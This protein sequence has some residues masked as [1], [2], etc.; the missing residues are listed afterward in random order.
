MVKKHMPKLPQ[1]SDPNLHA[2]VAPEGYAL[3]GVSTLRRKVK[4][5]W[6]EDQ[7]WVK[8][9]D[10]PDPRLLAKLCKEAV[11]A[12]PPKRAK[13][14]RA[15]HK[16]SEQAV[17]I[18][19]GD[20]HFGM[21]AWAKEAGDDWDLDI[22]T[23]VHTAAIEEALSLVPPSELCVI[24][25]LGDGVHADGTSGAT[26]AG[27]RVDTD[28]RWPKV[29]PAFV[30]VLANAAELARGCHKQVEIVNVRGNHDDLTSMVVQM[31]LAERFRDE[32]RVSVPE[33]LRPLWLKRFG[34]TLL[35]ATHGDKTALKNLPALIA[36][37]A[38]EE[39]GK[40][41]HT[42]VYCGH[43]HHHK[44]QEFPG[45]EVEYFR[46]LAAKDAWHSGQGY[47]SRRSL[48]VDVWHK[49]HGRTTR[50]ELMAERFR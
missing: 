35:A 38:R 5:K 28:S 19:L 16:T 13:K 42:H 25:N 41:A 24:L 17:V 10:V 23:K 8:T 30:G 3:R 18:A 43:V 29:V 44:A 11:E 39:W 34:S 6:V 49:E 12:A 22:A 36:Q 9:K 32:P 15:P 45:I 21:L 7:Q 37:D 33:N 46:T 47:R 26:T 50:H 2:H 4:G 20:P 1:R 27:T 48:S 40:T 14:A 31:V